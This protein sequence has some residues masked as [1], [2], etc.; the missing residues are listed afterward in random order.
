MNDNIKLPPQEWLGY[1]PERG[2][3][4]G[5]S[6]EQMREF[7]ELIIQK[8]I[9][10]KAIDSIRELKPNAAARLL[11]P[12]AYDRGVLT[13]LRQALAICSD[14]EDFTADRLAGEIHGAINN[15]MALAEPGQEP[16]VKSYC[17]GKPNYTVPTGPE[18]DWRENGV[19]SHNGEYWYRCARCGQSDW[20]ATRAEGEEP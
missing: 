12:G 2:N 9:T 17:G 7:T 4:H 15:Q 10:Q 19:A 14:R 20:V 6:F 13:G 3:I 16:W 5:Y 8:Y 18:H 1:D 11:D